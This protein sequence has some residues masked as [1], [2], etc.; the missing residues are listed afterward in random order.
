MNGFFIAGTDTGVGKTIISAMLLLAGGGIYWK[1]VQS[2][3]MDG[4]DTDIIRKLTGLGDGHFEKESYRLTEPLSPHQSAQMEN[5]HIDIKNILTDFGNIRAGIS[6]GF[7]PDRDISTS[8]GGKQ[9]IIEGAGGILVPLNRKHMMADVA[10]AIGFPVMLVCRTAL[11]TINHTLLTLEALKARDIPVAGVVMNG[12]PNPDNRDAI[13]YYGEVR[14]LC[15]IPW[16]TDV[17]REKLLHFGSAIMQS[18]SNTDLYRD[19]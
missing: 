3:S 9:L 2:G 8:M 19:S 6:T 17:T 18:C 14:V 16:L 11:G 10:G 13:E 4:T 15:T 7:M 1:P 12:E 5:K